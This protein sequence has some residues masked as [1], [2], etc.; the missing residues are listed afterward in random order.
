ME[1]LTG[2]QY[3]IVLV[4]LVFVLI[5][6]VL[7]I[8][9]TSSVCVSKLT[10]C[11]RRP[12]LSFCLNH[13]IQP[14]TLTASPTAVEAVTNSED[15]GS[16]DLS[17][18]HSAHSKAPETQSSS[19]GFVIIPLDDNEDPKVVSRSSFIRWLQE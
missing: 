1:V 5:V 14:N 4:V 9:T 19:T 18:A 3:L 11:Y 8:K 12:P 2:N 10:G 17:V 7:C 6:L 16:V 13:S 15:S